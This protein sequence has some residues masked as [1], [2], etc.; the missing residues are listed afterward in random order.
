MTKLMLQ[1]VHYN[2]SAEVLAG[3]WQHLKPFSSVLKTWIEENDP[4]YMRDEPQIPLRPEN[5]SIT[6]GMVVPDRESFQLWLAQNEHL[7]KRLQAPLPQLIKAEPQEETAEEGTVASG[8]A[9]TPIVPDVGTEELRHQDP[10]VQR[11]DVVYPELM[12]D[13]AGRFL[14]AGLQTARNCRTVELSKHWYETDK[15]G[16]SL[17]HMPTVVKQTQRNVMIR[18]QLNSEGLLTEKRVQ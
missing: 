3:P 4:Q 13:V 7:Q 6:G 12:P 17:Y 9:T 1:H 8:E 5:A 11:C 2:P 18:N 14:A 15:S 10:L 16:R